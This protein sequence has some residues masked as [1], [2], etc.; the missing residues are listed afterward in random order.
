MTYVCPVRGCSARYSEPKKVKQHIWKEANDPAH[1]LHARN[2]LRCRCCGKH[3]CAV[4]IAQHRARCERK[5][6]STPTALGP[7][8]LPIDQERRSLRQ[9]KHPSG[10]G[11]ASSYPR[12]GQLDTCVVVANSPSPPQEFWILELL[13]LN[14]KA[15]LEASCQL[16]SFNYDETVVTT[17]QGAEISYNSCNNFDSYCFT[18][19]KLYAK[20][21]KDDARRA[22]VKARALVSD[23][24]DVRHPRALACFLEVFIHL[25]QEG[26]AEVAFDLCDFVKSKCAVT[27]QGNCWREI[28]QLLA[29]VNPQSLRDVLTQLWKCI[30]D[31]FEREFGELSTFSVDCRLDYIKRVFGATDE[32]EEERLLREQLQRANDIPE[33]WIPQTLL[34]LGHNLI[35]QRRFDD[36]EEVAMRASRQLQPD[37]FAGRIGI[38]KI[39]SCSQFGQEKSSEAEQN[40]WKAI[41][42]TE[43]HSGPQNSWV[44]EFKT[45]L[46]GWYRGWGQEEDANKLQKEIDVLMRKD[47]VD[48]RLNTTW[49]VCGLFD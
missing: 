35:K 12:A 45:V 24:I 44:L 36:A 39:V 19:T 11:G 31:T 27:E 14:T 47:E 5:D 46:E 6:P 20:G 3:F 18:A 16:I 48:A 41:R 28:F 8:R 15:H 38:L 17:K 34:N 4:G 22:I 23:I 33:Y 9:T 25:I 7:K 30:L 26:Q 42:M 32:A 29:K 21:L 10:L 37:N 13:F 49:T 2:L 40:M 43:N 1:A